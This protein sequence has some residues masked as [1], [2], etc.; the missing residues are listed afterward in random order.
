MANYYTVFSTSIDDL[1]IEE[2]KWWE[3]TLN[4][5][6]EDPEIVW[7]GKDFE[8]VEFEWEV[9]DDSVWLYAEESGDVDQVLL[10]I[11]KFLRA[12]RP[13]DV[14]SLS[15]A[16]YCGA[17]RLNEQGGGGAVVT[18]KRI[19]SMT[20][21]EWVNARVGELEAGPQIGMAEVIRLAH[22]GLLEKELTDEDLTAVSDALETFAKAQGFADLQ[23]AAEKAKTDPYHTG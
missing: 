2:K 19:I 20:T 11:Q 6:K 23:D 3:L 7:P 21:W 1:S 16:S 4:A 17:P 22:Y 14:R 5:A 10:L 18:S 8:A 12:F 13:D 15:W 9:E